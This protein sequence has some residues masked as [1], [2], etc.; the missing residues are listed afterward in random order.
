MGELLGIR[1]LEGR[2]NLAFSLESS[3]ASVY[4]LTKALNG[5]AALTSR[6]GAIAGLNVE[7]LLRRIERKPLSGGGDFR[8]GKTPY[9]TLT[10]NLKIVNGVANVEDVRM[11]G[12]AVGLGL[13][14]TASIPA[15]ELDLRGTASLLSAGATVAPGVLPAF[16]LP[17]MVQGPWNDPIM[18]PDSA[19]P[20]PA[21]RRGRTAARRHAQPRRGGRG[22]LSHRPADGILCRR[23]PCPRRREQLRR[24][25][26]APCRPR[27]SRR[28]K[29]SLP[30][31]SPHRTRYNPRNKPG[32]PQNLCLLPCSAALA[33]IRDV[34]KS[35]KIGGG[36]LGRCTP[37]RL[38]F[39]KQISG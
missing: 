19:K 21:L 32:F 20:A 3:G 27:R 5:T 7:Q 38:S 8:I 35:R 9:D 18:L 6:K 23:H 13:S 10:V 4:A 12:A 29:P 37:L 14:G 30:P 24:S 11:E 22:P 31:A 34:H 15:R 17:F 1:R 16:E 26:A 33:R 2:G 39:P 28:R 36:R 25:Q